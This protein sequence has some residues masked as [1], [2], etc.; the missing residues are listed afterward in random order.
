MDEITKCD[1]YVVIIILMVFGVHMMTTYYIS[2]KSQE[3]SASIEA[4]VKYYETNPFV[5]LQLITNKLL[6]LI[7]M[8]I[9][10]GIILFFYWLLRNRVKAGKTE[11]LILQSF[12]MVMF[13][14]LMTNFLNDFSVLL[15]HLARGG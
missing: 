12:V 9:K 4:T 8:I 1:I 6:T 13:F 7:F 14:V 3:T 10:P 11:L 5:K 2:S 15:G